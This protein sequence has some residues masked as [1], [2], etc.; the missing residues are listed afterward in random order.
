MQIFIHLQLIVGRVS[1]EGPCDAMWLMGL[2]SKGSQ[3]ALSHVFPLT[4][5]V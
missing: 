4:E 3:G 2:G 1:I 5:D